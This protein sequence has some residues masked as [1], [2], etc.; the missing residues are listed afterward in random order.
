M[1]ALDKIKEEYYEVIKSIDDSEG[2]D[3]QKIEEEIGDLLFAVVNASRFLCINPEVALN[4]AVNK[5][6]KRF[7]F[8]ETKG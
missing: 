1:G 5:F 3:V 6:I 2:G 8:I 7:E 4:K